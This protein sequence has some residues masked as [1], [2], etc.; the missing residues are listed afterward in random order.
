[1]ISNKKIHSLTFPARVPGS[2]DKRW[3]KSCTGM[4]PLLP[5]TWGPQAKRQTAVVGGSP[6]VSHTHACRHGPHMCS[7][8]HGQTCATM[9]TPA[10]APRAQRHARWADPTA[11]AYPALLVGWRGR[12][13]RPLG[14]PRTA[15]RRNS[16]A[17]QVKFRLGWFLPPEGAPPENGPRN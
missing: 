11:A 5:C 10:T 6:L 16:R 9:R 13:D 4:R 15:P 8:S 2:M 7:P 12:P 17:G 3:E 1:M 14:L